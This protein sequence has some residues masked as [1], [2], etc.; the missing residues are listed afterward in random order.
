MADD[1]YVGLIDVTRALQD[2]TRLM[3][4]RETLLEMM[5]RDD[6]Y[7]DFLNQE[8]DQTE[9]DLGAEG[10]GGSSVSGG[11]NLLDLIPAAI[12]FVGSKLSGDDSAG[13]GAPTQ[14]FK[15]G[16][17]V[18]MSPML[19]GLSQPS[20]T[21]PTGTSSLEQSGFDDT[22]LKNISNK[23][24]DD[25][26]LDPLV[27][28]GFGQALSMPARAAAAHLVDLMSKIPAQTPEQKQIIKNN[29][30]DIANAYGLNKA[31]V[32]TKMESN[33][34]EQNIFE[35]IGGFFRGILPNAPSGPPGL[36]GPP[37]DTPPSGDPNAAP[38]APATGAGGLLQSYSNTVNSVNNTVKG[39]LGIKT[40]DTETKPST[41]STTGATKE[42]VGDLGSGKAKPIPVESLAG[43]TPGGEQKQSPVAAYSSFVNSVNNTFSSFSKMFGGGAAD[44]PAAP[45]QTS[46]AIDPA[47]APSTN[48]SELTERT[49]TENRQMQQEKV[50]LASAKL[51]APAAPLPA[52]G[53]TSSSLNEMGDSASQDTRRSGYFEVYAN[54]SQYS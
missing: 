30:Q 22:F 14:K 49:I 38:A 37:G 28:K 13:E 47:A 7:Q 41:E 45:V 3:E 8:E 48:L 39:L 43:N 26:D 12:S 29:I 16:G 46:A 31:T 25:F 24:E 40:E 36:P 33:M 9:E 50:E 23:L 2:V 20:Q 27:K 54:T 6:R 10:G 51:R 42:Q 34:R 5:F 18:G 32:I 21:S 44:A 1:K 52:T 17:V 4:R 53:T 15:D 11:G 19:P 35:K